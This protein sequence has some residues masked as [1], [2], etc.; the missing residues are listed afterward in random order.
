MRHA[1]A[2][3]VALGILGALVAEDKS[4]VRELEAPKIKGTGK[5]TAPKFIKS[6]ADLKEI[7][8]DYKADVDFKKER[9]VLFAWSGSGQDKITY[10]GDA[11]MVT[12]TVN[13]GLTRDLRE[14]VKLFAVPKDAI[15]EVMAKR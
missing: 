9:L 3:T 13:Y 5:A 6:E 1:L 4:V 14:H 8:P 2:V 10:A 15:V 11:K 7:L 12:F